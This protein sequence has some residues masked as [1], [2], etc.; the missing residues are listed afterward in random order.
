M[1]P[2]A[3]T[4]P[5][6]RF[7]VDNTLPPAGQAASLALAVLAVAK[8]RTWADMTQWPDNA[9]LTPGQPELLRRFPG[10][11]TRVASAIGG[12][13]VGIIICGTCYRWM[14]HAGNGAAGASC[15]MTLD[16]PGKPVRVLPA[17]TQPIL[18]P[19]KATASGT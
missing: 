10:V 8:V 1:P 9:V 4:S 3:K 5:R 7:I 16:C 15:A 11:Y 19:A 14:L 18:A 2:K 17:K 12:P 13:R 6:K